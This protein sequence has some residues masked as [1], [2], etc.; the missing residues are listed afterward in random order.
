MSSKTL[1]RTGKDGLSV[2]AISA[3]SWPA[4]HNFKPYH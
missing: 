4:S 2:I 3:R 1:A